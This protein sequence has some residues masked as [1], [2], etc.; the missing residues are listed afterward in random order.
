MN[1]GS[2]LVRAGEILM[3]RRAVSEIASLR[4]GSSSPAAATQGGL[5]EINDAQPRAL[6]S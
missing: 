1:T 3:L 4:T 2:P 6:H 5:M